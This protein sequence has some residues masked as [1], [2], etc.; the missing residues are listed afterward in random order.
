[1]VKWGEGNRRK[2][3]LYFCSRHTFQ[4]ECHPW[5][6]VIFVSLCGDSSGNCMICTPCH[7]PPWRHKLIQ[8]RQWHEFLVSWVS[9]YH[10]QNVGLCSYQYISRTGFTRYCN[11]PRFD[12][13][14][15]S[16]NTGQ[17]DPRIEAWFRK[18]TPVTSL[19]LHYRY[20]PPSMIPGSWMRLAPQAQ[21][22]NYPSIE[23]CIP[24]SM[25]KHKS[26]CPVLPPESP[27]SILNRHPLSIL[28]ALA[29]VVCPIA[30]TQEHTQPIHGCQNL[31]VPIL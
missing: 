21:S 4:R 29:D 5:C 31:K 6:S 14:K 28:G 15:F 26:D 8:N 2:N 19:G 12:S 9:C 24:V 17:C 3:A 16:L 25:L 1:M 13:G 10:N 7:A 18:M 30:N 27:V 20:P 23:T 11:S 22:C